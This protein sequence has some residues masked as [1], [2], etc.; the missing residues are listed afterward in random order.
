MALTVLQ[1]ALTTGEIA[2]SLFGRVDLDLFH[3]GASTM[4]NMYPNYKGGSMSRAG[5][6]YIG[7]CLQD[8]LDL[9]PRDI[10]FQFNINQGY[11]LEFGNQYLRIKYRGAYVLE[12]SFTISAITRTLPAGVAAV[13]NDFAEDDWVYISGADGLDNLNNQTFIIKNVN[14]AAGTFD[15][16]NIFN[17]PVDSRSFDAYTGAGT[18]A[19][20][21]TISSPYVSVD[22][23][24]IKYDQSADVMTLV[25]PSYR[26]Y[27]LVRLLQNSWTLTPEVFSAT[28]ARPTGISAVASLTA[29]ANSASYSYVVTTVARISREESLASAIATIDD[30]ADMG[31]FENNNIITWNFAGSLALYFNI[32]RAPMTLNGEVPVGSFFG[33]IGSARGRAFVDRNFTPDF[34]LVP[35]LHLNPFSPGQIVDTIVTPGSGYTSKPNIGINTS[36]GSRAVLD[37]VIVGGQLVGVIIENPGQ[38]YARGDT[39]TVVGGG[40]SGARVTLGIGFQQGTYP[41]TVAYFQQRRVYA[42]TLN[43][44]DT[45]WMSKPGAYLNM[46]SSP[47]SLDSDAIEGT[48]WA[49]Q[50]NGI[51]WLVPMPR[52]L[53]VLTGKGAW[54]VSGGNPG[55]QITPQTQDAQPQAYNGC[56]AQVKPLT[57][58]YDILYIQAKGSIPRD[59]QYNFNVNIYMGTDLSIMSSHLF[60]NYNIE[61]WAYAEEPYKII[62][63][64]RDNGTLLSLT[65]LKELNVLGWARHDTNGLFVSVCVVTEPPIDAVYFIVK[66]FINGQWVYMSERMDARL[67][68]VVED[69][70][71]VDCGLSYT[72][73]NPDATLIANSATGSQAISEVVPITGGSNFVSPQVLIIDPTGHGAVITANLSAG[74]IV[75]F[76]VVAGGSGYTSPKVKITDSLGRGCSANAT[77]DTDVVMQA[78]SAVFASTNVGDV[79]R[80]GNGIGTIVEFISNME[81]RVELSTPITITIPDNPISPPLPMFPGKWSIST[82]ITT[83][84]GLGHLEGMEVAILADGSVVPNQTVVDGTIELPVAAS[85]IRVGLPFQVQLQSMPTDIPGESTVQGKRK[86]ISAVT[87]RV[88]NSRGAEV[89]SNQYDASFQPNQAMLPW[90]NLKQVKERGNSVQA[91]NSIPLFTG[92]ERIIIPGEWKKP[93]QVAVQQNFPLPLNI[94]ALLPE[95]IVGDDN[96]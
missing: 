35:P 87:V 75:S 6:A 23:Q 27:Q 80:G 81:V 25:H 70:W 4:R 24:L 93:G 39:A 26:P 58:N 49:Q 14:L 9:P 96:G 48:P 71:C 57:I 66:R 15:L 88:Q 73:Q 31:L 21:L 17:Q 28:V 65:Y 72:P 10:P 95:V 5:T 47:V 42:G 34:S 83:V 8:G 41:S 44:P 67:W 7:R 3:R 78:S 36:T 45:Y 90:T 54:Q 61:Q 79:I 94:L 63:A 76:N 50:V 52:G 60:D 40:G 77:I 85:F 16:Y 46:D 86:N 82:P 12:D 51:Q 69:C 19:R 84:E 33:F 37:A 11:A 53:V 55:T 91:G 38:F 30:A 62:W 32:Y 43:Q 20:V 18:V 68:Q 64:V 13:G 56:N 59:L 74:V 92:D 89:G 2:P 29:S 22:L 1:T